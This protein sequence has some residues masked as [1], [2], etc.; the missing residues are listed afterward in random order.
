MRFDIV[1][2]FP[3]M[4]DSY[5]S[6]SILG[7]AQDVGHVEIYVHNLRDYASGKHKTTDDTP[8]GGGAGMVMM[9]EPL[10]L[11]VED[12]LKQGGASSPHVVLTSARGSLFSQRKARTF[13][14]SYDQVVILCGRYEGVDERVLSVVD[15]E[16]SI[17]EYVLTGGEL[18]A[19]VMV[20]AVTRLLPGVVGNADSVVDESHSKEGVLEYPQYTKPEE[21]RGMKVPDV[22]LSGN[23]QKIE[24]WRKEHRTHLGNSL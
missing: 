14:E 19:M 8:Y 18:P 9:A 12:V 3:Q 13:S 17:G 7:R 6:E 23:H 22:L 15:E 24:E 5:F 2:I 16:A 4:F 20:D 1:S 21:L 11:A 10:I